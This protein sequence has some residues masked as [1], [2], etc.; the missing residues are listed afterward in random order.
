MILLD[1]R[2]TRTDVDDETRRVLERTVD[3]FETK[4]KQRIKEDYHARVWY[5]DFLEFVKEERA[6]A[7]VLT[8]AGYGVG[9]D[10]ARWDTYRIGAF[11]EVLG[12]YGLQY[13]YT[14]QVTALGLGPIWMSENEAVKRR[15][16]EL[17]ADGG[18]FAFGLSEKEHGA[19]IY[20]SHMRL[21]ARDDGTYRANGRKYYIGNGNEASLVSTFGKVDGEYVFFVTEPRHEAYELV[22]NVVASQNYV[23]EFAL[24]DYPITDGDILSRG[25]EAW[26]SALNTINIC[27][28]NLGWASIGIA[29][30]A[31][32][33]AVSH[34]AHRQLY[35]MTVTDFPHVRRL[36]TDAYVR[37][38]A[39]KLFT[40]RATDYLRSASAED[41]RYLLYNPI[42][43]MKVTREGE[44]AIDLAWDVIAA[45]GFEKDMYFEQA[46]V[47]IRALP[48]LEGTVHVNAALVAKFMPNYL[49]APADYPEIPRR[50]DPAHDAFLF[51][52]G[53]TKGLGKVRFHDYRIAFDAWDLPN[54]AIF[55]EQV[56]GFK[57]LVTHAPPSEDQARDV[58]FLLAGAELFTLI[59]YGQIVLEGARLD[60]LDDATVNQIFDVLIRDFSAYAL[61]LHGKPSSTPEQMERALGLIRKPAV[62]EARTESVWKDVLSLDGAY[63]MNP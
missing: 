56:E 39:M 37:V 48:K 3:F 18:I 44:S 9:D 63:A 26:D 27:K 58:D 8:P 35:G 36:L 33:E 41:R 51:Q 6:F 30:H 42:V 15:T 21:D 24:H 34:A 23:S 40:R 28:F 19:D 13:W 50:D 11:A 46:A 17:L 47:D 22:Q 14:W 20:S 54:V 32:Y 52:Q 55:R 49:F 10:D 53:S 12:F 43:K 25:R 57:E 2:A 5:A 4:G 7:S 1:P 45:K 31:L 38:V 62:D 29:T 16:A 59:V 60:G 61:E